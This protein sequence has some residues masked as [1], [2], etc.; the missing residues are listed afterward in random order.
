MSPPP[1]TAWALLADYGPAGGGWGPV[2]M[3]SPQYGVA[4]TI[5]EENVQLLRDLALKVRGPSGERIPVRLIRFKIAD[6]EE[7]A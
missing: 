4:F 6:E 3:L 5:R 1:R 7:I 2:Y